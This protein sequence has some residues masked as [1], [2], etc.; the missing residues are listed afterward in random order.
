M[1]FC[2]TSAL[3]PVF[4]RLH[5]LAVAYNKH[6]ITDNVLPSGVV[7]VGAIVVIRVVVVSNEKHKKSSL[8]FEYINGATA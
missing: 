6:F 7:V 3:F 2:T 8:A 1:K 4:I 5:S